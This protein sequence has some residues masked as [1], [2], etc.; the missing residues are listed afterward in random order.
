[1]LRFALSLPN[2]G[3]C[4][5]PRFLLELAERTEAAGWDALFLEDYISYQGGPR[6][7]TC[8]VWTTLGP[9]RA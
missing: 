7:P 1:M 4:G 5:D 3:E 8:D 2:G 9:L 6:A